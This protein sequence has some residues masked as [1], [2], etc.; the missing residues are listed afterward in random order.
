[1]TR[2]WARRPAVV[3]LGGATAVLPAA[4]LL[5]VV[6]AGGGEGGGGEGGGGEGGGQPVAGPSA[7]ASLGT[8]STTAAPPSTTAA[9]P[10]PSGPSPTVA[11]PTPVPPT[12]TAPGIPPALR[13]QDVTVLPTGERVVALTFDAGANS[14]GL[15][16]ILTTLADR[17]VQATFFLTGR[18]AQADPAGVAAIR[19]G[20]HRIGN[21]SMTHPPLTG[22]SEAAVAEEVSG[23][24]RVLRSAGAD[25]RPLFRFPYGD[26]DADTIATVNALGYVP[27]RWTVD[28][29]GW[30]GTAGGASAGTVADRAL[31]A[32]QPGAIVLMHIGSNPD[33]GTT[34][35]ADALPAVIDRM[36]AAGYAF[37][38]LDA[39]L[40]G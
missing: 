10:E 9:G 35:D 16:G 8:Q 36:R 28:T 29:L 22:R 38:T 21:H 19:A 20:G 27:V 32:L 25:P 37:V 1:M 14:A 12:T 34:F 18:W 33:D 26:R 17:D 3:A 2:W 13:G 6:L 31:G 5:A 23:A 11:S 30:Q 7:S 15:P 39:V 4:V 40:G 24:E